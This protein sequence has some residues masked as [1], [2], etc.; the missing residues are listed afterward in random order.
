MLDLGGEMWWPEL[1]HVLSTVFRV[2]DAPA[3]VARIRAL[4]AGNID[5][6][7]I[8]PPVPTERGKLYNSLNQVVVATGLNYE[9]TDQ[10]RQDLPYPP[11]EPQR[12][13]WLTNRGR[14]VVTLALGGAMDECGGEP[15]SWIER[16]PRAPAPFGS[17]QEYFHYLGREVPDTA[18]ATTAFPARTVVGGQTVWIL[19]VPAE[20]E[21]PDESHV[22]GPVGLLCR[23]AEQDRVVVTSNRARTYRVTAKTRNGADVALTVTPA[24]PILDWAPF[25]AVLEPRGGVD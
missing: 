11:G 1:K 3:A 13:W 18:E 14:A 19:R 25:A 21:V 17:E 5:L 2:D 8:P 7:D 24:K 20:V 6:A 4:R 12:R 16:M 10:A 9:L 22:V 23:V 15:T